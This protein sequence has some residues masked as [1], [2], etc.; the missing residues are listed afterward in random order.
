L[1]V[2]ES[3]FIFIKHVSIIE[4]PMTQAQQNYFKNINSVHI[5]HYQTAYRVLYTV[6]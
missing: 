6:T 3:V 5:Y 2:T 4:L 1:N